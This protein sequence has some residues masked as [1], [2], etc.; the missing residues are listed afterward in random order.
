[1]AAECRADAAADCLLWP[2]RLA[3][4]HPVLPREEQR[5]ASELTCKRLEGPVQRGALVVGLETL[6][7]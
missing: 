1:M 2:L 7:N 5:S 3:V 4:F 6:R